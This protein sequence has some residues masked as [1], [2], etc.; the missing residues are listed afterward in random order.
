VAINVLV[1][2]VLNIEKEIS[3]SISSRADINL[4]FETP[5]MSWSKW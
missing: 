2:D 4:F 3:P 5:T 1:K